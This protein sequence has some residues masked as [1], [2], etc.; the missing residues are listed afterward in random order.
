MVEP[1]SRCRLAIRSNARSLDRKWSHHGNT[2]L[3]PCRVLRLVG[4]KQ[5]RYS[6]HLTNQWASSSGPDSSGGAVSMVSASS[7]SSDSGTGPS[8]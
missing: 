3:M 1:T 4:Q 7:A 2:C 8:L 5:S 6:P